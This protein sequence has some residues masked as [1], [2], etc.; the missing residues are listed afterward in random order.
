MQQVFLGLPR[1]LVPVHPQHE[2]QIRRSTK[3]LSHQE[4][5]EIFAFLA[6]K[7]AAPETRSGFLA[8]KLVEF[9]SLNPKTSLTNSNIVLVGFPHTTYL[10]FPHLFSGHLGHK[11]YGRARQPSTPQSPKFEIPRAR[12]GVRHFMANRV[13]LLPSCILDLGSE[14]PPVRWL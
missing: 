13:L 11:T 1:C 4:V 9:S 7:Q 12:L 14:F 8:R 2:P 6:A 10:G 5:V 3:V